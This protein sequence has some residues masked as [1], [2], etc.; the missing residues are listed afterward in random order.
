MQAR[1]LLHVAAP[2]A[3]EFER[4]AIWRCLESGTTLKTPVAAFS[5]PVIARVSTAAKYCRKDSHVKRNR[6]VFVHVRSNQIWARKRDRNWR[7]AD[8]EQSTEATVLRMAA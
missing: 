1:S 5:Y 7:C 2:Y 3:P 8:T 6:K 4:Y